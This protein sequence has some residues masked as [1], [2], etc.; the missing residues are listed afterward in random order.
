[1]AVIAAPTEFQPLPTTR[2]ERGR[3]IAKLGGIRKLG[4][5][6]VVPA[7]SANANVPTYLVDII[8][9]T[10]TCPDF[11]LRRQ[12]CK[13]YEACMFWLSWE[14]AVNAET[15]E[16]TLPA[17][18]KRKTYKQQNWRAYE[19]AQ[20]TERERV[21]QL[22][23]SLCESYVDEPERVAGTPG[24]KPIPLREALYAVVMKV[25]SCCSGRRADKDIKDS[26]GLG[27]LSKKWAPK[28]LFR[29]LADPALTPILI[30]LI[31]ESSAPLA[32]IEALAGGQYA[33][34]S[35]G[36]STV[37]YERWFD[38]KH[39]KLR[40]EHGWVKLH[41]MVGTVTHVVTGVKVS[42]EADC[43]VLPE[44][45]EQTRVYHRVQEVSADKA[46][47]A[48]YNLAAIV[49]GGA[50]PY[51]PF[52]TNSLGMAS[53][54]PHWRKMW[55][56]FQLKAEEFLRSYHRRSNVESTIGSIKS[57]CGGGVRCKLPVAQANEVLCKVLVHNL[58]CIV[59]AI[60]K[61]GIDVAFPFAKVAP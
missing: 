48:K 29:V 55:C 4:A 59:H 3:Q 61:Y 40:S 28:T 22:L 33:Q 10:C 9:Q 14:G 51:I 42:S 12:P 46:Y 15:G 26:V 35:T 1:M 17:T 37:F 50:S 5:R 56:L 34:D 49:D 18:P 54:S 38:Q 24:R 11:E 16:V 7:Q 6:Y 30:Q 60:E 27:H 36:F 52:K 31:M 39:G 8:E 43:P 13:H 2:E 57:K 32:A 41:L 19:A 25:Y 20:M 58:A 21:P 44:T 53:K 23:H 45:L 47:L